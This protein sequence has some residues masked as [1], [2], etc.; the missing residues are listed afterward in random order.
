MNTLLRGSIGILE[1]LLCTMVLADETPAPLAKIVDDWQI[2]VSISSRNDAGAVPPRSTAL[3]VPPPSVFTVE[4]EKHDRLPLFNAQTAGWI[5]GARLQGVIA[6]E[7]TS[8]GMLDPDSLIL[9]N[10]PESDARPLVLNKDF[11]ADLDWGTF[12][13][14]PAGAVGENQPVYASYRHGVLRID[15]IVLTPVGKIELRSGEP[16]V[17]TPAPPT[18]ADGERRLVNVFVPG[19]IAKLESQHLFPILETSYPEPPRPSST[20]AE[21]LLP[22]AL[23]KLRTG[24]PLRILAWGDSVTDGR[25]LPDFAYNRWQEQFVRRLQ[26]RFPQARIELVT[27]AWGGRS[28]ASYLEAPAGEPHNYQETVLDA[29]P[30]LIVSEF[31][32]DAGLTPAQVE[33]RY[34]KFLADFTSIGAEWIILTPHY[35]RPDWMGLTAQRD[36]DADPRPYVAGLRQ[37]AARHHVA[38]A[39]ASLRWGRLWR[40]GIPYNT[41]HMNTINHPNPD[42]MR[43]FVDSLMALFP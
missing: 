13:R 38:L 23:S 12:G 2:E 42:G 30:D 7:C 29:R 15:S 28:T 14:L 40:Q 32:N 39:D 9:R 41:L 36:I 25:Y 21:Q 19:R 18:L 5:K 22:K 1:I 3:A 26:E 8:Y 20:V 35:V 24:Q 27:E 16:H 43:L 6:Q 4:S 17:A 33:E 37:F 31:V 11:Q 10:G 34:G